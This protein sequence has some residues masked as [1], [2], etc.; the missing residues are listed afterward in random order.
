MARTAW[1]ASPRLLLAVILIPS[2][3]FIALLV[4]NRVAYT[5]IMVKTTAAPEGASFGDG[6]LYITTNR[7]SQETQFSIY[8][9]NTSTRTLAT[10][11]MHVRLLDTQGNVVGSS[12]GQASNIVPG[13]GQWVR[14][15]FGTPGPYT[16]ADFEVTSIEW[17]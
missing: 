4:F 12:D 9:D 7:F 17:R 13:S 2:F 16:Q 5:G 10:I 14:G 15:I 8:V 3:L 11:T 1:S 6:L